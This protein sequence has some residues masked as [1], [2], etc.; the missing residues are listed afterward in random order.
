MDTKD[1]WTSYHEDVRRFI[2][3]KIKDGHIVDD[4]LQETFIKV[5]RKLDSLK[6][7]SKEALNWKASPKKWSA[8]EC[9]EHMNLYS[10]IYLG[11][12]EE[13]MSK[14]NKQPQ[15]SYH[16]GGLG[17]WFAKMMQPGDAGTKMKTL[18]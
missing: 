4:L 18:F 10:E 6:D 9:F 8:L 1:I 11:R 2:G 17:N 13:H 5:H 15:D 12:I 7:E 3:S 14:S 16:T